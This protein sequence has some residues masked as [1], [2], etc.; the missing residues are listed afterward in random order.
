M[1]SNEPASDC[2][3]APATPPGRSAL[4]VV[5]F[6]GSGL[7][8]RLAPVVRARSG[9]WP[10]GRARR[11]DLHDASG[12]FDDGLAT[13][14]KGPN[15]FTGE[16]TLEVSC[17]GNPRIVDRLVRAAVA[18]GCR[19]AEPGE[20][21][22]RAV[23]HGKLG[24]V[25]AE[26]VDQ[27]VRAT[28]DAGIAIARAALD[29]ELGAF[30]SQVRTRL[31]GVVAELEARMDWPADELAYDT[32]DALIATLTGI[33]ERCQQLAATAR[34]GRVWVD[35]ARVALV[36]P[37]NAGKSSLFN[38]LLGR[39]RALVHE[40]AGTTRDV[41][42]AATDLD[43][44]ALTL[45][46]TAG[47]RQTD[48]PVEA[49]GLALARELVDAADALV[50]VVRARPEGLTEVERAILARTAGRRRLVVCNGVDQHPAPPALDALAVSAVSGDGLPRL[51]AGLREIL[52]GSGTRAETL[53]IA[54]V[55][56]ADLLR[57]VA[58]ACEEAVEALPI[59]GVAVSA[60]ALTHGIA[61]LDGLTGADTREEVLDAVF[62]RFCI[63]K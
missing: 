28:S 55:R 40:R 57:A 32:D 35:G 52:V 58:S 24:L 5:R 42:E 11:V 60:D 21:T 25:A 23:E 12:R 38:A 61:A 2:I 62:A 47:E 44:L 39:T 17:H 15:T 19:L 10:P 45:M 1:G 54:S 3:V 37:V 50:V 9:S 7:L 20:F 13:F 4:A 49:A 43:G 8:A 26:A 22:R 27:V 16:D 33:G 18:A 29:G 6:S 30:L 36:G 46:D 34:A 59:A 51:K 41:V 14:A 31:V 48:D 63:G 53:A 56:Q